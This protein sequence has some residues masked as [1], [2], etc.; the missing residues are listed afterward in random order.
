MRAA[1]YLRQ[2]L[3]N[4]E[5]IDRQRERTRSLITAR[6]WT[7]SEVFTD[8]DVSASKQRGPDT[9]W[10]RMLASDADVVVAVDLDRLLRD[11]R[12]LSV[13]ID[14][15][16]LV[17][18]VDGEIDLST[19]DGEFRA[20][21]LAGIAR[22]E[23]RRKS[24]RQRRANDARA[25]AG[26][27]VG[28]RR[29]FGF[30]D[31]GMTVREDEANAIREGFRAY[32]GGDTLSAVA[33]AWTAAGFTTG[34]GGVWERTAV[35]AVLSNPRYVGKVRHRGEI[36]ADAAW[37]ALVDVDTWEATQSLINGSRGRRTRAQSLLTGVG[38]CGVCDSP[39]HAG[40]NARRGVRGYRCSASLGHVA[41]MAEPVEEYVDAL[42]AARLDMPDATSLAQSAEASP[43]D[44]ARLD[45]LRVRRE[46]LGVEF[47]DGNLTAEQVRAA[48]ERLNVQI[49][50]LE[51]RLADSGR[52]RVLGDLGSGSAYL[53]L[54]DSRRRQVIDTLMRVRVMPPGRGT[55]TFRP[56][57]VVIEWK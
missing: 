6:G 34:Q 35:R 36:V 52:A 12:D 32:V 10:G 26:R 27:W 41:R 39:L 3:D 19:A 8:N 37:P 13:L 18:T 29:P 11:V 28:G 50:D 49:T 9:G 47:A 46:A 21:M 45:A 30:E 24:E 51:A 57:S 17:V 54:S 1:I 48:T 43:E 20:T 22:F 16:K 23:V 38:L 31:N 55:R 4:A 40:G 25:R 53:A 56:E 2:S 14:S 5:G 44:R 15:G 42:V 7:L 33:R